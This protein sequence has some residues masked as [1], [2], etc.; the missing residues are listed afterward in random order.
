MLFFYFSSALSSLYFLWSE[1]SVIMSFS[2]SLSWVF[3]FFTFLF[4]IC[5]SFLDEAEGP[6][7][8]GLADVSAEPFRWSP[9]SSSELLSSD[10][11]VEGEVSFSGSCGDETDE[12]GVF[13]MV[14]LADSSFVVGVDRQMGSCH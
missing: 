2:H 12:G 8:S 11:E 9:P 10:V 3:N 14:M 7:R 13:G 5:K 4:K 1:M 6:K